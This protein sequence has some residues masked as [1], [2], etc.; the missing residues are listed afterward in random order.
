MD[1][2][3]LL[4]LLKCHTAQPP[5]SP[6]HIT[7]PGVLSHLI[8]TWLHRNTMLLLLC[9]SSTS[10]YNRAHLCSE[11]PSRAT[12]ARAFPLGVQRPQWPGIKMQ[13]GGAGRVSTASPGAHSARHRSR[14]ARLEPRSQRAEEQVLG[15]QP[16]HPRAAAAQ[17]RPGPVE[18]R[19][20]G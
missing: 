18:G 4:G 3:T 11:S 6:E 9:I 5:L 2:S 1:D 16:R 17:V 15:A 7:H 8:C 20:T 12:P 19:A 14:P 13:R 10:P